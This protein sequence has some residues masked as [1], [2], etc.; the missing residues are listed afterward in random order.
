VQQCC[1]L[2][3]LKSAVAEEVGCKS[4]NKIFCDNAG[5]AKANGR[6]PKTCLGRVFNNK[7]GCFDD[8]HVPVYVD[9]RPH[10]YLK[11]RPMFSPVS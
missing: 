4:Y 1:E 10:L 2:S 7:L 5:S 9:A 11:T 3:E 8:A 6:E